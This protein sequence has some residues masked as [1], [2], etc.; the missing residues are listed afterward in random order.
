M[1]YARDRGQPLD[2]P[3]VTGGGYLV[4]A[5]MRLGPVRQD[6]F[7]ERPVDWPEID[8]FARQTARIAEP[9]EAEVLFDMAAGWCAARREGEDTLAMAPVDQDRAERAERA[10]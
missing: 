5:L 2:L 8:A 10:A 9:W 7:G 3:D 4:E 1:Q 6:G